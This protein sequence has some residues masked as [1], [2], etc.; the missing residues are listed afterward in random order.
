MELPL[1]CAAKTIAGLV[2]SLLQKLC[3]LPKQRLLSSGI[4]L[5]GD[6]RIRGSSNGQDGSGTGVDSKYLR[7]FLSFSATQI[8]LP[9]AIFPSKKK[10]QV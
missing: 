1:S 9:S 2:G 6:A 5:F 4:K 3:K 8:S 7:G 10:R